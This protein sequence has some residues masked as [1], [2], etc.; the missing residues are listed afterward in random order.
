MKIP[1]VSSKLK[2]LKMIRTVFVV[3]FAGSK[4]NV[5]CF[6]YGWY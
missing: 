5:L 4:Q 6:F 1:T 3:W 2:I